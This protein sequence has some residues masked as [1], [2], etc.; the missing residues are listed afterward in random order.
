MASAFI[1]SNVV[2]YALR[3]DQ[4]HRKS[5]IASTLIIEPHIISTQ[6]VSETLSTLKRKFKASQDSCR[7]VFFK[8]IRQAE[9]R[10]IQLSTLALS[11][12]IKSKY[13][14]SQYDSQIIASALEAG[15]N[16]LYTEDLQHGQVIEGRLQIVNPFAELAA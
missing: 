11:L 15:C 16:T 2:L 4:D 12:D 7:L 14:Y 1:D 5:V 9:V 3:P 6:V 13:G 10:A 8:L